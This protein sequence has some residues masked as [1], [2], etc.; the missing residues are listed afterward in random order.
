MLA[1]AIFSMVLTAIYASWS[2]ILRASRVGTTAAEEIQRSR[3]A[4]RTIEDALVSTVYFGANARYYTFEADTSDDFAA[5]SFAARLPS[6]FPGSGY[7]GDQVVRRVTFTVEKARDGVNELILSQIPILQTNQT[8][9]ANYPIVLARDVSM[10]AMEFWDTR[11]NDWVGDW[12][13]TNQLPKMIKFALAFGKR[14]V[15]Q[16]TTRDITMRIVS[17]A[18]SAVAVDPQAQRPGGPLT[19]PGGPVPGQPLPGPLPGQPG[20]PGQPGFVPTP[21]GGRP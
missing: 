18:S 11:K 16:R 14:P 7:F 9:E 5:L 3:V 12:V 1:V 10:F 19:P 13:L 4:A 15:G 20:Q 21:R 17:L 8:G 6:S 2:A